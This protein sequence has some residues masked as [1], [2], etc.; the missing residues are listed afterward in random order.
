MS[1]LKEILRDR[2]IQEEGCKLYPYL[3]PAKKNTIGIGRNLDDNGLS[4]AELFHLFG[5]DINKNISKSQ[6]LELLKKRGITKEES[7]YLLDNDIDSIIAELRKQL[8]VFNSLDVMRQSVLVDMAFNLGIKG[9]LCF[10]MMLGSVYRHEWKE[11]A[12]EMRDSL[13]YK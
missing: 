6:V 4:A 13:W 11:A 1:D 2:L 9:L 5:S 8:R 10:T 3:C 7:L 12:K